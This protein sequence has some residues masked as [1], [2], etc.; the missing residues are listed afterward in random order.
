MMMTLAVAMINRLNIVLERIE[1][2]TDALYMLGPGQGDVV[3]DL[4][5]HTYSNLLNQILTD[6]S[7]AQE[8]I[9]LYG[10]ASK[11]EEVKN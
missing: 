6:V 2:V 11:V 9:T 7:I 4:K 8:V 3:N 1:S 5:K 10:K